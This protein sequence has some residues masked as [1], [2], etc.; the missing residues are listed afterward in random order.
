[1]TDQWDLLGTT[2]QQNLLGQVKHFYSKSSF[3]QP[4][5]GKLPIWI[6]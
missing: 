2:N 3:V 6:I 4:V 1:M 5:S